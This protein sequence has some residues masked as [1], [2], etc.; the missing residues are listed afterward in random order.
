MTTNPTDQ[1]TRS[2]APSTWMSD[3]TISGLQAK[4][5]ELV[6]N[7]QEA[8]AATGDARA[9]LDAAR[10]HLANCE[11]IAASM[12]KRINEME[13]LL[14]IARGNAP[15]PTP[16]DIQIT[17]DGL[18]LALGALRIAVIPDG[19]SAEELTAFAEIMRSLYAAAGALASRADQAA[20]AAIEER[21]PRPWTPDVTNPD[22][23]TTKRMKRA[24]NGCGELL[25]DV[26]EEEMNAACE[27]RP[28]PDVR[29]ECPRCNDT[30]LQ[31]ATG[32]GDDPL[33]DEPQQL[34]ATPPATETRT[35]PPTHAGAGA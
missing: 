20:K 17:D 22:G 18:G 27:G 7:A 3:A 25:G 24:C 1:A 29:D 11:R 4:Y 28:L 14:A 5:A 13:I 9:E 26:T 35:D 8:D 6:K 32:N 12:R 33:T 19:S 30:A 2:V 16:A 31:P 23:S 10:T 34:D 21:S 15:L